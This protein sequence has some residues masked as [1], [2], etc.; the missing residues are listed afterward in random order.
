MYGIIIVHFGEVKTTL[1][2][3]ASLRKFEKDF[4]LIIVDNGSASLDLKKLLD[5]TRQDELIQLEK[6]IGFGSA[7]NVGLKR[8][9]YEGIEYLLVLNN[10]T[11][12]T[13]PFLDELKMALASK[14]GAVSPLIM[15]H[16]E[17]DKIWFAGGHYDRLTT[18]ASN[19]TKL[20]S[21]AN[22]ETGYLSGCCFMTTSGVLKVVGLFDEDF[23]FTYEDVDWS[24][25]AK[26]MGYK[27]LVVPAVSILHRGGTASG[28][29]VSGFSLTNTF[30]SQRLMIKKH[31]RYPSRLVGQVYL[32]LLSLK[33][34][35][36]FILKREWL[37]FTAVMRGLTT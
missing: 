4:R 19:V 18:R 7:C 1:D 34:M 6:N 16:P 12:L 14:I 17:T 30:H 2:C 21:T 23:F 24:L 13:G 9:M 25:R 27:L 10:D 8:G 26:R 11:I 35:I 15:N 31:T 28:G 22:F 36:E 20:N 32:A 3:I 29:S 37:K 33:V 5:L